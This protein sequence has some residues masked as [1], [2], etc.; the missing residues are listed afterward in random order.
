MTLRVND[1]LVDYGDIDFFL[2][3]TGEPEEETDYLDVRPGDRLG[4]LVPPR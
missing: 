4:I 2:H 3:P 1:A